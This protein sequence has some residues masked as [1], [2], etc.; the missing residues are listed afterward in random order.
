MRD[1]HDFDRALEAL[2]E[3]MAS[4]VAHFGVEVALLE[5][6]AVSSGALD[7]PLRYFG[8]KNVYGPLESEVANARGP[9]ISVEEAARGIADAVEADEVPLR[10]PIGESGRACSQAR[11]FGSHTLLGRAHRAVK[12]TD[13]S[14]TGARRRA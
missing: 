10:I 4:E 8:D 9:A 13:V 7:A 11:C 6:G 12:T 3:T 14:Q 5:P 2:V 1:I